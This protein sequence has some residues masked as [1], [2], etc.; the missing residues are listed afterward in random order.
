MKLVN[1]EEKNIRNL[2]SE[3]SEKEGIELLKSINSDNYE[4]NEE[5]TER[6]K[7]NVLKQISKKSRLRSAKPKKFLIAVGLIIILILGS[8]TQMVQRTIADI[9]KMIYYVP[10]SGVVKNADKNDVYMLPHIIRYKNDITEAE[11]NSIIKNGSDVTVKMSGNT[12]G[13]EDRLIIIDEKGNKYK[14]GSGS[15]GGGYGWIGVFNFTGIPKNLTTFK[16]MLGENIVIPVSLRKAQ[17]Y[18]DYLSM[19]PTSIKN[20]LGLTLIPTKDGK[21]VSIEFIEHKIKEREVEL[22][23][24]ED[25][26][27]HSHINIKIRDEDGKSYPIEYP[28]SYFGTLS[29]FFFQPGSKNKKYLLEIPEVR[30]HYNVNDEFSFTIAKDSEVIINKTINLMG[31]KLKFNRAIRQDNKIRLYVDNNYD[32][33]NPENLSRVNLDICG[34]DKSYSWKYDNNIIAKYYEFQIDPEE[35]DIT[36][37]FHD[38][39]TILKGP[40]EINFIVK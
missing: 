1:S 40:W 34:K 24:K 8:S 25:K 21:M 3:L 26:E 33:K 4:M 9:I 12:I 23:G 27:G 31:F 19:G 29:R 18:K 32:S 36:I 30:M 2:I 13:E 28:E 14:S 5:Q 10:G 35:E 16:V 37:K 17:G 22:Y 38:M 39:H 20:N 7:N 15:T 6:I 11:I